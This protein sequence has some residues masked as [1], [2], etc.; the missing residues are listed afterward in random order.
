MDKIQ[1]LITV[2]SSLGSAIIGGLIGGFFAI[3]V[4]KLNHKHEDEIKQKE[5]L[6]EADKSKPRLELIDYK[7]FE[8]T[9][10]S[11]Q[12]KTDLS[13]L[14]LGI[15]GFEDK[16]GRAFFTYD[17]KA[18]NNKNLVYVEYLFE[19]TGLT[20]IEEVCVAS[21]LPRFVSVLNMNQKDIFIREGLLNYDVWADKRYIKTKQTIKISVYYIKNQIP[22][23]LL[24]GPS[25]TIWLKDVNGFIWF[26]TL[27]APRN[28][29]EISRMRTYEDFREATNISDAIDCFRNP[30]L[31]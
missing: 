25:L 12:G 17:Q 31:W 16:E 9:K 29:I 3:W 30:E 13:V 14:V 27:L 15:Q 21:D 24:S 11:E 1:I 5:R 2:L 7:D 6:R 8:K 4:A 28:E 20:E 19:N 26:Q 10:N 18:L 22:T 23:T